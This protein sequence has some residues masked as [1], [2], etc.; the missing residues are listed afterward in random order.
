ML[1]AMRRAS[2]GSRVCGRLAARIGLPFSQSLL[3][4]RFAQQKIL[5]DVFTIAGS[6]RRTADSAR[7]FAVTALRSCFG[8][9]DLI[10]RVASYAIQN[11]LVLR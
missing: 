2:R 7:Y 1:A 10:K 5:Q 3:A 9:D 6:R 4:A 11:G 8:S